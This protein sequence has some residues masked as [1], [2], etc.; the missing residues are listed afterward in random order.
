MDATQVNA[1]DHEDEVQATTPNTVS[2][3]MLSM[4]ATKRVM[5]GEA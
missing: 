2:R 3:I 4:A 5:A 1:P